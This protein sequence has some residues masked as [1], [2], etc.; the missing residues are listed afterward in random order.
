M[1]AYSN[2]R[3]AGHLLRFQR[4]LF[5]LLIG[6]A[7]AAPP[8]ATPDRVW[9]ILP[10]GDSITQG[11]ATF[12]NWRLE[13]CEKLTAAG[14]S[15][16]Y[17]GTQKS[18]SR[19]GDLAH[20]GHGGKNA[21]FLAKRLAETA[22]KIPADI[23]LIHAGHNH[24][25]EEKPVPGIIA[26]H[27]S[28]I[29]SLRAANPKVMI[30]VAKVIPS[31]KLPKYSYIPE[32]NN[33]IGRLAE[34]LD[35]ADSPVRVVDQTAGFDPETDTIADRVHPNKQGASKM[36]TRWFDAISKSLPPPNAPP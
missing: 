15:V 8:P 31:G 3:L 5:I 4:W 12:S 24:F 2:S 16:R 13:L 17:T 26:A 22:A 1:L 30:F 23:A 21:E 34:K 10:I 7:E 11:G 27:E 20:E 18:P 29:A 14:W 35:T 33:A 28:I 9:T 25:A 32:L 36:A 6:I 19:I